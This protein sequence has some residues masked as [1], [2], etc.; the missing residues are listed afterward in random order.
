MINNPNTLPEKSTLCLPP[1]LSLS[2]F[3]MQS[4]LRSHYDARPSAALCTRLCSIADLKLFVKLHQ[5]PPRML[6]PLPSRLRI[7]LVLIDKYSQTCGGLE[8]LYPTMDLGIFT[9]SYRGPRT[10]YELPRY[11][12][13]PGIFAALA[14][15]T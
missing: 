10:D 7:A 15:S 13:L 11:N 2:T 3:T 1:T 8:I 5:T 4:D 14:P 9:K 12:R 6:P